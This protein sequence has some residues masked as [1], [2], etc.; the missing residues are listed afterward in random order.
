MHTIYA[1]L[2]AVSKTNTKIDSNKLEKVLK[3][4]KDVICNLGSVES[5][6]T[7]IVEEVQELNYGWKINYTGEFLTQHASSIGKKLKDELMNCC[8]D[9]GFILN[10]G[11]QNHVISFVET[12][13]EYQA[14]ISRYEG[15]LKNFEIAK[16][17]DLP[18]GF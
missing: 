3:T 16:Q 11:S 13:E 9:E 14:A 5:N 6:N 7:Y 17:L 15:I 10:D 1:Y 4:G 12:L 2:I 18:E 8:L